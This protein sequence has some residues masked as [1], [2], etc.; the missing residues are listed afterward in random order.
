MEEGISNVHLLL[1]GQVSNHK[2]TIQNGDTTVEH[3]STDDV[4]LD[5]LI[6]DFRPCILK[7][8]VVT[9]AKEY[10]WML[11]FSGSCFDFALIKLIYVAH[12]I[13]CS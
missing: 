13:K 7:Q 10:H 9:W 1:Y 8:H 6:N 11:L 12:S 2:E 4:V 5:P 3:I